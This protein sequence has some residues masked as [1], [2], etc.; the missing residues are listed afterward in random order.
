MQP[1]NLPY[2]EQR[3]RQNGEKQ[4]IFD[5]IRRR[6]VTL[7]PEEWVRQNV[8]SHLVSAFGVPATRLSVETTINF[9]GLSRRCDA[10]IYDAKLRP[11]VIV[12]YKAA[13]IEIGQNVFDQAA[14]YNQKLQV[15][16]L[17][18]SNGLQHIFCLVDWQNRRYQFF[19]ELP[20]YADLV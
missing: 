15:P 11:L 7:T 13:T 8:N 20:N 9:N 3:V 4:Q 10:V 17:L 12:E 16:Y 1:L 18:V 6:W 5:P 19:P 2:Y 14:V